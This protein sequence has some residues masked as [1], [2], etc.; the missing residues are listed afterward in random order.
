MKTPEYI[1][2][3]LYLDRIL[4]YVQKDII[5]IIVGQRGVGKSY[6]L[7][8]LMDR[9]SA[10]DPEGQQIYINKELHE[11]SALQQAD[12][13]LEYIAA[14]R[15]SDRRLYL[16]MDEMQDIDGFETALRSLQAEG[17]VDIYG[18]GSNANL[19]SGE[20][21]TYL[22]GR[23]IEIKVYGLTY[24]EFIKF[25]GLKQGR[26]SLQSY[27]KFGG[28]PYLRHL[29]YNFPKKVVSMDEVT[30]NSYRGIEHINME[31]FLLSKV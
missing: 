3:P 6:M 23:Y 5:K 31:D 20:L 12:D 7:F 4:P 1:E 24:G 17:N 14:Y 2:R 15:Q 28:L 21:A 10:L 16:F 29:P 26:E 25:H 9:I 30:G 13:L 8:Q 27:L 22:S 18:T 19:L 11:Y